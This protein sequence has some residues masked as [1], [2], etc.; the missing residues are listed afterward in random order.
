MTRRVGVEGKIGFPEFCENVFAK[1]TNA[2]TSSAF[3][4][5][6]PASSLELQHAF[7]R[8]GR[9]VVKQ[10]RNGGYGVI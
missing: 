7:D 4:S 2:Q 5:L 10:A 1:M 8:F 6:K 3:G 9:R